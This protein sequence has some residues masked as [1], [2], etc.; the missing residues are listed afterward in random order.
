MYRYRG[1]SEDER[2]GLVN[3]RIA[4]GFPPHSPPHFTSESG[5][6][7]LSAACYE[8]ASLLNAADRRTSFLA[9]LRDLLEGD[10]ATLLGW[11]ILPNH[12]HLLVDLPQADILPALLKV[13]HGRS[14]RAWNAADGA[15][16]RQV[17]YRYTDR[18]IRSEAHYYTTL[19]YIHYNP[20][21]HGWVQSPYDWMPSSV[22]WYAEHFGRDW[23]RETWLS[24]PLRDYGKGWDDI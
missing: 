8:H 21:K 19:N 22:E 17:W 11:V 9:A 4:R 18:A 24:H 13:A 10:G 23:L 7:L 6:Y 5:C 16:G 2:E 14:S 1:L 15:P 12:Y 3:Q 20:V